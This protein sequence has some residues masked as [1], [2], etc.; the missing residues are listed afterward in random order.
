ME[1]PT[2]RAK[3]IYF[4]VLNEGKGLT[5]SFL[6]KSIAEQIVLLINDHAKEIFEK[7][8]YIGKAETTNN[9]NKSYLGRYWKE[10]QNELKKL[11]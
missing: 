2:E 3:E 11:E 6:S 4:M 1:K 7:F 8:D 9:Y 5:S 10:V